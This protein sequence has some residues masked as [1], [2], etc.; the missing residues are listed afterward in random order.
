VK[1]WLALALG[2]V[3]AALALYLL[4]SSGGDEP[5]G[6]IDAA[7]RERLERVLEEADR[8]AGRR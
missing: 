3:I 8:E 2:L 7:S 4:A 5:S 1:R 6:E